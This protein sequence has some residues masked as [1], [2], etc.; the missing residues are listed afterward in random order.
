M[1]Q[2]T[3]AAQLK[4]LV[5]FMEKH[6]ALAKNSLQNTNNGRAKKKQLWS[7]LTDLLN[8]NGPPVKVTQAW[9]K[10]WTDYKYNTKRKLTQRMNSL[11]RTGGGP[12]DAVSLNDTEERIIA[13]AKINEHLLGVPGATSHGSN[14]DHP[15][16]SKQSEEAFINDC[17]TAISSAYSSSSNDENKAPS[18]SPRDNITSG[19]VSDNE[20]PQTPRARK[21]TD[22]K[23]KIIEK[24]IDNQEKFQTEML[25]LLKESNEIGQKKLQLMEKQIA[26]EVQYKKIKVQVMEADL[27]KVKVE[28]SL[29][30]RKMNNK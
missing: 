23:M 9:Q 18:E 3:N 16:S 12:Y 24:E 15:C 25:R 8:S 19:S 28:L 14:T 4:L 27:E 10:V 30:K 1:S 7:K 22:P 21:L 5:E 11:K 26:I 2:Q 20:A 29:L 17:F 13:V 6:N